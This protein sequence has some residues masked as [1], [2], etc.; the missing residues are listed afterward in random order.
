MSCWLPS[1]EGQTPAGSKPSGA[2]S[3]CSNDGGID[4][5]S[6]SSTP[7]PLALICSANDLARVFI[8]VGNS[9]CK[10][11]SSA[12]CTARARRRSQRFALGSVTSKPRSASAADSMLLADF[13][14]LNAAS[15]EVSRPGSLAA[16]KSGSRLNVL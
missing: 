14:A 6:S 16:R 9:N 12:V 1:R 7:D 3:L 5:R 11:A 10:N 15:I 4:R 2:G 13:A 8:G